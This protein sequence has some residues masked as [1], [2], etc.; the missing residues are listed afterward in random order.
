MIIM[1]RK[2]LVP[3]DEEKDNTQPQPSARFALV[4]SWPPLKDCLERQSVPYT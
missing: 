4:N 1:T 2:Y 3:P